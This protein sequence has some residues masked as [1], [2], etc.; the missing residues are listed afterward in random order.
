MLVHDP[1]LVPSRGSS[2]TYSV[3]QG[4]FRRV[5]PSATDVP[6]S[7]ATGREPEPRRMQGPKGSPLL[8]ELLA[9]DTVQVELIPEKKGLFLKHVEYQVASQVQCRVLG[10]DRVTGQ[11]GAQ[12][13]TQSEGP[14]SAFR[15]TNPGLTS[16]TRVPACVPINSDDQYRY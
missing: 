11:T 16:L 5:L 1:V 2:P 6:V 10:D 15:C 13:R 12:M 9:R 7:P 14:G 3:P 8:Q 4:S